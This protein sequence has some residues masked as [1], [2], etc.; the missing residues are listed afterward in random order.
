MDQ[1]EVSKQRVKDRY[2]NDRKRIDSEYKDLEERY[3]NM[4]QLRG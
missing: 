4:L 2:E 3:T 1:F